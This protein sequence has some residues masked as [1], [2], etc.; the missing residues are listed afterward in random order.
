MFYI[1]EI[2]DT[3]P[4]DFKTPL[5]EKVYE[6]LQQFDV[7]FERVDTDEAITMDDCVEISHKLNAPIVKTLFLCNRQQT[8]FYLVVTTAEKPFKTKD[9]SS[10]LN[11]S[12]LSFASPELLQEL[13]GVAVG[14]A[15]LFGVMLDTSNKVRVVIDKDVL[16]NEWYGCSDGTTTGYM[17]LSRDWIMQDF[18]NYANHKPEFVQL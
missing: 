16:E 10:I 14:A 7:K 12:R 9:L 4:G 1:S 6:T 5:H 11:I 8:D 3:A 15:T 17:K 2:K 18:L 13:L